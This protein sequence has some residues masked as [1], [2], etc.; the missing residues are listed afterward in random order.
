[1]HTRKSLNQ[2]Q[3]TGAAAGAK[4]GRQIHYTLRIQR[5]RDGGRFRLDGSS[6]AGI[7]SDF[8]LRCT[9]S[10]IY[11][12]TQM[13]PCAESQIRNQLA[14]K[15]GLRHLYFVSTGRQ[16]LCLE[17]ATPIGEVAEWTPLVRIS[18]ENLRGS[19]DRT[20]LIFYS[21]KDSGLSG[22][23]REWHRVQKHN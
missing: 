6:I 11:V 3:R 15:A 21:T 17:V 4:V 22:L 5:R 18:N 13:L 12:D 23:R 8:L 7:Y 19:N 2:I 1:L 10:K 16:I 14:L 20:A 9:D